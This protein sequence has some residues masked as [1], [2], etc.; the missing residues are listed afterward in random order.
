M[1]ES[2]IN[3][4]YRII[5][6]F[7]TIT[8]TS[9]FYVE[10]HCNFLFFSWWERESTCHPLSDVEVDLYFDTYEEAF[11]Y[12]TKQIAILTPKEIKI[13][14]GK[15]QLENT[16]YTDK[17]N[18]INVGGATDTGNTLS[19]NTPYFKEQ[20]PHIIASSVTIN[21]QEWGVPKRIDV[22]ENEE[23]IE[24]IY[25]EKLQH[26]SGVPSYRVFK[27]VFSCVDGKW[28]KSDRIYGKIIPASE[29]TYEFE[30]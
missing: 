15:T 14:M 7:C 23:S 2:K 29:E 5:E 10:K 9:K 16:S 13:M 27:I 4:K 8:N 3:D 20:N 22:I 26:L 18:V 30:E 24:F 21:Y 28:N 1:K 25:K 6:E 12:Q 19:F 17:K 11:K